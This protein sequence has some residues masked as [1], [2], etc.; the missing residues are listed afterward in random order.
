MRNIEI[1]TDGSCLNN[2]GP[3]GWAYCIVENSSYL[4]GYGYEKLTTNNRMELTAAIQA[5]KQFDF[6]CNI[7]IYTD[8][9][10][11]QMGIT[12]WVKNWM[13]RNWRTS[14]GSMVLNVDLWQELVVLS[15]I[16][17]TQWVWVK[18]HATDKLNQRVDQLARNAALGVL[19]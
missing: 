7:T 8:S 19:S 14:S 17:V 18:G 6:C 1:W 5:L 4:D 15:K 10:Y 11:V 2:P 16:H 9:K 12:V 13:L 3:G